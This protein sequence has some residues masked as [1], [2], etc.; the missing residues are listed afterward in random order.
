MCAAVLG[1]SFVLNTAT[2]EVVII[3]FTAGLLAPR[4]QASC[5]HLQ[6][7][8]SCKLGAAFIAKATVTLHWRDAWTAHKPC[9]M[10]RHKVRG[11]NP[12]STASRRKLASRRQ[13]F[14]GLK[15]SSVF[16][17]VVKIALQMRPTLA[18]F[19][20]A[21]VVCAA[22]SRQKFLSRHR[23]VC[24]CSALSSH[25]GLDKHA[26]LRRR[27]KAACLCL[28]SLSVFCFLAP[29]SD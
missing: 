14:F 6:D 11:R 28:V 7:S 2:L 10:L 8:L 23:R 17:F 20:R 3:V 1:V 18:P 21:R 13:E 9:H 26:T 25:R 24:I 29:Q 27:W 5:V 16:T 12:S 4:S 19:Q 15:S 22:S